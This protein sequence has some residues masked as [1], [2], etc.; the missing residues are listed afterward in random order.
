MAMTG[1]S[2]PSRV[3]VPSRNARLYTMMMMM[4]VDDVCVY[5]INHI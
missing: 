4:I 5:V 2:L 3:C 1:L